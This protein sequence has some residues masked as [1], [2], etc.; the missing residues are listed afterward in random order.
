MSFVHL[1]LHTEYP[2]GRVHKN[3]QTDDPCQRDGICLPSQSQNHGTMFGVVEFFFVAKEA[4]IK[5]IIGLEGYL[6]KGSMT[7]RDPKEK[8]SSHLL[9]LAKDMTGYKNLLQICKRL[10]I[11]RVYYHPRIDHE[12]LGNMRKG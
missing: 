10:S 4:G 9:L 12:Y 7:S 2:F 5:P 3:Q 8:T 6:S 1:H 11:G